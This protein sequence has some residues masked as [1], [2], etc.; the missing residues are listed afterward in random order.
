MV[1]LSISK[2]TKSLLPAI[3][4][5]I[6]AVGLGVVAVVVMGLQ[7]ET[8]YEG[9]DTGMYIP[10]TQASIIFSLVLLV[11]EQWAR[12]LHYQLPTVV[13]RVLHPL[14]YIAVLIIPTLLFIDVV[15]D[16]NFLP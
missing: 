3:G 15:V 1:S 8:T 16:E 11:S 13:S 14:A 2:Q 12:A 7:A 5:T 6:L 10:L 9:R 4:Y